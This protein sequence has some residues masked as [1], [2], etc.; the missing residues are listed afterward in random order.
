[1]K[2]SHRLTALSA[3]SGAALALVAG[4]SWYAVTS[5]QSDLE[6]LT[7]RAAPLQSKTYE[8]QERTERM[9]GGLLRLSLAQTKGDAD[10]ALSSVADDSQAIDRL[11]SEIRALDPKAAGD[12]AGFQAAQSE[13]ARAV[14]KRLADQAAYQRES[15]SARSALAK[16]EQS[17]AVTRQAVKQIGVDA[18]QA[19]DKA[20]ENSRRLASSLKMMLS[21]QTKL[22]E[23]LVAVSEVDL[24]SNR[25]RLG[26]IRD[27]FKSPIDG[28]LALLP[29]EGSEDMLKEVRQVA[30]GLFEAATKD[31]SGLLALRAAVLAKKPD[32]EAA[33][34]RQHKAILDPVEQQIAKLATMLD[35]TEGQAAK[36]RQVLEAALKLRNEPGGVVTTSE[37]VS[38]AIRD[39]VG[40][41]RLLML[42]DSEAAV[43]SA[44]ADLKKLGERLQADLKT[45]RAG[46]LKM[47]RP[48]LAAQV[49]A[50]LAAMTTVAG[51]IDQVGA[52]KQH[53]LASEAQMAQ[54]L[55]RLKT[56][57]AEQ[58]SVGQ[59][60]VQRMS[61]RQVDVVAAVDR[62][63]HGSLTIIL[64]IAAA[65]I[66]TTSLLSWR[67]TRSVT[68]RLDAAVQVAEQVSR[69]ELV[70]VPADDGNDETARLMAAMA[71][72]VGTL[73]GIVGNIR[74]A[75]DRIHAG[76]GEISS[77]NQ[78]LST[79]SEHQ[80]SQLQQ[81]SASVQQLTETVQRN[82]ESARSASTLATQASS[83]AEQGGSLVGSVVHTMTEIEDSSRQIAAIVSV[84]DGIAFQT[85]ILAL[86]AAVEA[87]RAGEQGRGFAVVASEVRALAGKS[88]E[89][90]RE[91]KAIVDRSVQSITGG[92]G[93]VRDAGSTMQD[94]VRQVH[95]VSA[96]ING[97]ARASDE[98][99]ASVASVG[100]AVHTLDTLTQQNAALAEQSSAAAHSLR[101]QA[102]SLTEAIAVFR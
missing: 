8:V 63:V 90:A 18:G 32:A 3:L 13:I 52:S 50:A 83:V 77:G 24:A 33:Y 101:Q 94:I 11:R 68:R 74:T 100:T 49:D 21:A 89:A 92:A 40:T 96:L 93:L 64:G 53:L 34:A 79:R 27:R 44:T 99:A 23:V 36:Q 78:D 17:V 56:M 84:I 47:G 26:P 28:I 59:A 29:D 9:M 88:A 19:A 65:A 75:A 85:N 5:I 45:M 10:K 37:E 15:E 67:L 12:D 70:R 69:G 72:M 39:M 30:T 48:P 71:A 86:N 20:Q 46:L 98:Q 80:A 102:E 51:S 1:M 38:L 41:L 62:R 76:S 58:A 73:E 7:L 82:A 42:A 43:A 61:Q 16:A 97:I 55:A 91:V 60:Q 81:T 87:A 54:S 31:G 4:V 14:D 2:I 95:E 25:F 22:R 6:G 35:N 66:A 57:A